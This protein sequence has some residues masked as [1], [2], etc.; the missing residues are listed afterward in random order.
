MKA[1]DRVQDKDRRTGTITGSARAGRP[2]PASDPD[3]NT[4]SIHYWLVKWE[5]T[6]VDEAVRVEDLF[7]IPTFSEQDIQTLKSQYP[8]GSNAGDGE[9]TVTIRDTAAT[10]KALSGHEVSLVFHRNQPLSETGPRVFTMLAAA[11]AEVT[12]YKDGRSDPFSAFGD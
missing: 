8:K 4:K 6:G 7:T 3:P 9:F 12:L 1:G 2:T 11:I 5:D 10:F